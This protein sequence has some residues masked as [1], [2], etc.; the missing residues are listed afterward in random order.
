MISI[1]WLAVF[2]Q[3]D[4]GHRENDMARTIILVRGGVVQEVLSEDE[5]DQ[6]MI[7]DYDDEAASKVRF[8]NFQKARLNM[9][10][11]GKLASGTEEAE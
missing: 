4:L 7:I 5:N 1:E 2:I 8:R 9:A 11:F 10:L 6:V 3:Y